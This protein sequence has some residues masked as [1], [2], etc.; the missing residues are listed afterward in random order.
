[1]LEGRWEED[2][3]C[4]FVIHFLLLHLFQEYIPLMSKAHQNLAA[5]RE[6]FIHTTCV[7]VVLHTEDLL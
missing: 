1:M 5:G 7:Y 4:D 6:T 2:R 3:R